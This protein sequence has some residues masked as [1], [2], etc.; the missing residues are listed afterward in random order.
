MLFCLN[1]FLCMLSAA[2]VESFLVFQQ[3]LIDL[4]LICFL[5]SVTTVT[6][7]FRPVKNVIQG[8]CLIPVHSLLPSLTTHFASYKR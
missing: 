7:F 1:E 6:Y 5:V 8:V 3:L 4:V 2:A